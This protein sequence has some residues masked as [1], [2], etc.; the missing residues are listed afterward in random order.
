LLST[1]KGAKSTPLLVLLVLALAAVAIIPLTLTYGQS[2]SQLTVS[3]ED[4]SGKTVTGFYTTVYYGGTSILGTGYTPA[5]FTLNNG[6]AYTVQVGDYGNCHFDHWGDTGSTNASR[7]IT[8]SN[9]TQIMAVYDCGDNGASTVS[10]DS[11]NQNG[12]AISGYYVVL[13]SANGSVMAT[14]LTPQTFETA[15]GSTYSVQVQDYGSCTFSHWSDGITGDSMIF[16]MTSGSL[17]L[18][19][20]YSCGRAASPTVG[21]VRQA[22]STCSYVCASGST[23]TVFPS[24]V[25]SGD[26]LAVTV[27][28]DDLTTLNVSDSL[29]TL[30]QLGVRSTSTSC[31]SNTGTCQ[32]DIYW[33]MLPASG[34][35]SV[36]VSEGGSDRALRVQTWEL[37]GVDGMAG[38]SCI[39]VSY[40]TGSVLLAT[41]RDAHGAGAGF[42]WEV[43]AASG[44][45]GSEYQV[46]AGSGS[47]AFPFSTAVND[48][49]A[50]AVFLRAP[51]G[52]ECGGGP[53][54]TTTTATVT[55]STVYR[56][57]IETDKS[58][59]TSNESMLISGS[60]SPA[61]AAPSNVTI[62]IM[63]PQGVVAVATTAA[64]TADG[65]YSYHLVTGGNGIWAAGTYLVMGIWTGLG[66]NETATTSF[67]FVVPA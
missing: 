14:G 59:Y 36:T 2:Q 27:V 65:S 62:T 37:S 16:I 44:V 53:G 51:S 34:N 12:S 4:A 42:T 23:T 57:S 32:A 25:R 20:A 40:P 11:V 7:S 49:E 46:S 31:D 48:V 9:A 29:G 45:A 15:I 50:A 22:E 19:A 60:V 21:L 26:V 17:D 1:A 41:G 52:I 28:S 66:Q 8:I 6:Q 61:P 63:G 67:E 5:V 43:Y 58:A 55:I 35:D 18:T 56:M 47:T 3:S 33:G 13:Y 54:T 30:M 39:P 64:S 24:S 10:I 38:G